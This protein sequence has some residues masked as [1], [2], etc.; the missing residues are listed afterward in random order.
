MSD[1]SGN[2]SGRKARRLGETPKFRS[3]GT[4]ERSSL[5]L[6]ETLPEGVLEAVCLRP[7]LHER[8]DQPEG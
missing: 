5:V 8:P 2:A 3:S 6:L 7:H 4:T 1:I